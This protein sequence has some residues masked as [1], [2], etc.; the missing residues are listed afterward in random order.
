M[1]SF[2]AWQSARL[3]MQY[4]GQGIEYASK[5]WKGSQTMQALAGLPEGALIYSNARD[6]VTFFLG[7]DS[8][9]LACKTEPTTYRPNLRYKEEMDEIASILRERQSIV[10]GLTWPPGGGIFLR[11]RKLKRCWAC[12]SEA[13]FRTARFMRRISRRPA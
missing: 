2:Y 9:M 7:R 12:A 13:L 1:V 4:H 3:V 6:A 5:A 8:R 11:S 10:P